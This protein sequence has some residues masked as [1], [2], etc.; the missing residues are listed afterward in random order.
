M[1]QASVSRQLL[2]PC[3]QTCF[4]GST[5]KGRVRSRLSMTPLPC[6]VSQKGMPTA[7]TNRRSMLLVIFRFAPAPMTS[8][9]CFASYAHQ[10]PWAQGTILLGTLLLVVFYTC[11]R[12]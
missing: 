5:E 7:S 4:A 11:L 10:G 8:S 6:W 12:E 1:L 9:G 3:L 2:Y